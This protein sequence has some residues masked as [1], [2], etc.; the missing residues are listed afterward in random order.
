VIFPGDFFTASLKCFKFCA[1][2]ILAL[3]WINIFQVWGFTIEYHTQ[4]R[5]RPPSG[6]YSIPLLE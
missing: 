6:H 1:R 5:Y 3:M 2:F 4:R